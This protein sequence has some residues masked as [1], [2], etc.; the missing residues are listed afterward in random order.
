MHA[1]VVLG[2]TRDS[3]LEE[4]TAQGPSLSACTGRVQDMPAKSNLDFRTQ[5]LPLQRSVEN[6]QRFWVQDDERVR[7]VRGLLGR[8]ARALDAGPGAR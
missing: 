2:G 3:Q 7:F 4:G 1:H 8:D 6:R 5:G